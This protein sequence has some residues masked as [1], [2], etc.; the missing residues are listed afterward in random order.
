MV[1]WYRPLF[2]VSS[3]VAAPS[4]RPL[5]SPI[6]P[7]TV[8]VYWTLMRPCDHV[9]IPPLSMWV[10]SSWCS[11]RWLSLFVMFSNAVRPCLWIKEAEPGHQN[12]KYLLL[13]RVGHRRKSRQREDLAS[14]SQRS[15]APLF[16]SSLCGGGKISDSSKI[17][18]KASPA[19]P[20]LTRSQWEQFLRI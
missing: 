5:T 1:G 17:S 10:I 6:P 8:A 4:T 20:A 18:F 7:P 2:I 12:A 13:P 19:H 11:A 14:C 16:T 3:A 9:E 15:T